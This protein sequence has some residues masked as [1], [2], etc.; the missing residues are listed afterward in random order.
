MHI[1]RSRLSRI[2]VAVIGASAFL[3]TTLVEA[4]PGGAAV[5]HGKSFAAKH[6]T[7]KLKGVCPNP[8]I[9]QTNWLAEADHAALYELIGAGGT[10]S[11]YS[12]EGPLGSTG[13]KLQII[14][15][16]PGDSF[17]PTAATLYSGNPV[18]RV[19]PDLTMDSS[20]NLIQL[21]KKFPTVG[22]VNLEDHDPQMLMYNANKFPK[23]KTI[24]QFIAAAKKGAKFYVSGL[25]YSYV[26]YL[27]R[28]GIP[29]SSFIGGYSGDLGRFVSGGGM[30]I[31]QGYGDSEPYLLTHD[32]PAYKAAPFKIKYTYIHQLG[33]DD[34]PSTIQVAKPKLKTMTPC[35][36][37]VVPLIQHAIV[38]YA[39]HPATVNKVLATFNPTYTA[40]Y[41]NTPVAESHYADTIMK[42]NKLVENSNNGKG[43]IGAF[44]FKRISQNIQAL[45]PIYAVQSPG[46]Y[47]PKAKA[48]E[49]VTNKFID[50]HIRLP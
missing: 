24:K 45:L 8:L 29:A 2:A 16:G 46:T 13:I 40:S 7:T 12:Y 47:N 10:M 37:R 15:G 34:Y 33:L 11:Q 44:Q 32:T 19:T 1:R 22:V 31:N 9:V 17:L 5:R 36:K 42:K 18:L 27:I 38:D 48:G 4:G 25:N 3:A 28:Q 43:P 21:S 49:V 26:Q 39:K 35:L 30:V 23:L 14:S 6:F 50:P 41:W 20:E